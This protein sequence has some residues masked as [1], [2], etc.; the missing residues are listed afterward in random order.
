MRLTKLET[1]VQP[2]QPNRQPWQKSDL[3]KRITGRRLQ[4]RN[5]RIKLRDLWTCQHCGRITTDLEI[6]HKVQLSEGGTE[7]DSN[8][9]ALCVICHLEKSIAERK[10]MR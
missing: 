6:D 5:D 10:L 1:R 2:L 9:N 3:V 7:D 4:A 8:V